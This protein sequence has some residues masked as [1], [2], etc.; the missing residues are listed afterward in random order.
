MVANTVREIDGYVRR[1]GCAWSVPIGDP[2]RARHAVGSD[3]IRGGRDSMPQRGS[4]EVELVLLAAGDRVRV[5]DQL[6]VR[7]A[8]ANSP[9]REDG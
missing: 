4:A 5:R 7:Q 2:C 1:S 6:R 3:A 9:E 8:D